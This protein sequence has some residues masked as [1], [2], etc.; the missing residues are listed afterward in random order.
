MSEVTEQ[1]VSVQKH[2]LLSKFSLNGL[3]CPGEFTAAAGD[4]L[5][6]GGVKLIEGRV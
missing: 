1:A 6:E 2:C 5:A 4:V 3:H